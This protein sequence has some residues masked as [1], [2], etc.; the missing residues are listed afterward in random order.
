VPRIC[1]EAGALRALCRTVCVEQGL[2]LGILA[3]VSGLGTWPPA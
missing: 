1:R 2:G 3:M